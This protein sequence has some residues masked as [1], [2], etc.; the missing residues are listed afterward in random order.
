M[1]LAH[2]FRLLCSLHSDSTLGHSSTPFL[3]GPSQSVLHPSLE[4]PAHPL[5]GCL[6]SVSTPCAHWKFFWGRTSV[7]IKA[8]W[9]MSLPLLEGGASMQILWNSL[10]EI[11]PVSPLT[12]SV[13][14]FISAGHG[15][16]GI[17]QCGIILLLE[18][19]QPCRW[20]PLQ[21]ASCAP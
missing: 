15:D 2:E 11:C 12:R 14:I 10:W 4:A 1:V 21:A 16:M 9:G 8:E 19:S 20:E 13:F 7:L 3:N 17:M 5:A 18:L 6:G